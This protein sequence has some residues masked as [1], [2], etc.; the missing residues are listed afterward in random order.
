M[1]S[2][3]TWA[4]I[5]L[6]YGLQAAGHVGTH[7]LH[8]VL[9][10][11]PQSCQGLPEGEEAPKVMT[12]QLPALPSVLAFRLPS[13]TPLGKPLDRITVKPSRFIELMVHSGLGLR[14]YLHWT[15]TIWQDVHEAICRPAQ[16]RLGS[17]GVHWALRVGSSGRPGRASKG[18]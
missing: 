2:G 9:S 3:A 4:S 18:Y 8:P 16:G 7:L 5:T 6:C 11:G 15:L 17:L 14:V 12:F 1:F 13:G 10:A